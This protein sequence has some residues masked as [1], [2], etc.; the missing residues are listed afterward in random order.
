[1]SLDPGM[2]LLASYDSLEAKPG[3]RI[4]RTKAAGHTKSE[5]RYKTNFTRSGGVYWTRD[6]YTVTS[7]TPEGKEQRRTVS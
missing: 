3:A 2:R 7:I 5:Q 4:S 6:G 1:M